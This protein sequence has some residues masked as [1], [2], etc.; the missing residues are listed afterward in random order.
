MRFKNSFYTF[1][2]ADA[3]QAL[4]GLVFFLVSHNLK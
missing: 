2:R 4:L 3:K 1:F